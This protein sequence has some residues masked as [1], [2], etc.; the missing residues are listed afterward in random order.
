MN[1]TPVTDSK[2]TI[3]PT[4]SK[5]GLY[6]TYLEWEDERPFYNHKVEIHKKEHKKA[7]GKVK[8]FIL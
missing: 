5:K 1:W 3:K 7:S 6:T 2:N 8:G 4:N